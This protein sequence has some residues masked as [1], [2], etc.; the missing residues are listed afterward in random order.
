M[1]KGILY[2]PYPSTQP[3][4]SHGWSHLRPPNLWR[5][6]QKQE[7]TCSQNQPLFPVVFG[8]PFWA[9]DLATVWAGLRGRARNFRGR[10]SSLSTQAWDEDGRIDGSVAIKFDL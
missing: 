6:L 5:V 2:P 4:P 10:A 7:V 1:E 9:G 8:S 3:H